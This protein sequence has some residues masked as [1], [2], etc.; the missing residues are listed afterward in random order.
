MKMVSIEAGMEVTGHTS[1]IAFQSWVARYNRR[2]EAHMIL[3][4]WGKVDLET[5]QAAIRFE[6][7]ARAAGEG[8]TDGGSAPCATV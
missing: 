6:S 5:L 4:R 7:R 3:R 1:K 2:N 8:E